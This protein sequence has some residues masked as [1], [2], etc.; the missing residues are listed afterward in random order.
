MKFVKVTMLTEDHLGGQMGSPDT[1]LKRNPPN[2]NSP[3]VG[4]QLGK[5]FQTR[6]VLM[7]C[8]YGHM[9]N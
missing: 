3:E 7:N 2:D 9:L 1:I 8:A 5:L 6:I 4:I